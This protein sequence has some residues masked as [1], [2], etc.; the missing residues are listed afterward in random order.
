M[1]PYHSGTARVL[2]EAIDEYTLRTGKPCMLRRTMENSERYIVSGNVRAW[3][4]VLQETDQDIFFRDEILFG[5]L[6]KRMRNLYCWEVTESDLTES[7]RAR[8]GII[9]ARFICAEG[10]SLEAFRHRIAAADYEQGVEAPAVCL[11][12][13]QESSRYCDYSGAD[14]QFIEPWWWDDSEARAKWGPAFEVSCLESEKH[15]KHMRRD[16]LGAPPQA[17]R[18]VLT[19]AVKTE[20]VLTQTPERWKDWLVLRDAKSAHPDM[21]IIAR[22]F[23][24]VAE[25][26]RLL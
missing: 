11:S 25:K 26:K 21:Q 9:T 13:A 23:C 22:M 24:E 12:P 10:V 5:D 4:D 7:E 18:A 16:D 20:I 6:P 3:R 17:A 2:D 19:K 8:H 1:F 15:Y 14:I